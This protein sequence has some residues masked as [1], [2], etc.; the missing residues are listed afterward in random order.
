MAKYKVAGNAEIKIDNSG[1]TLINFTNYVDSI[2]PGPIKEV[3]SLDTT[4]FGDSAERVIAGIETSQ[5][6]SIEGPYD[7]QAT[8]GPDTNL[9]L[10]VGLVGTCKFY[11]V[12]TASGKREV[13][14]QVLCMSYTVN[15]AVK[16][17][18]S[19]SATFKMD[20]ASTIGTV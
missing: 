11:P 7:D 5:E 18:V 10:L 4:T 16:E 15:M 13:I 9:G 19:Y 8:T 14:M 1:G 6:F 3:T 20:G 12:G 2:S 17:R